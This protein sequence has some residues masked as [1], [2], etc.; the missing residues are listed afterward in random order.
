MVNKKSKGPKAKGPKAPA[1]KQQVSSLAAERGG[2]SLPS[3]K[4]LTILDSL[5]AINSKEPAKELTQQTPQERVALVRPL[6]ETLDQAERINLLTIDL[7]SLRARA[8]Q[9]A[10][11]ARQQA[12]EEGARV[13][14]G[15]VQVGPGWPGPPAPAPGSV[16]L[17]A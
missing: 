1:K 4:I 9:L 10:E 16:L 17:Y 7:D 2:G 12:G 14:V 6:W 13:V 15:Y 11:A 8:K 5:P 3:L